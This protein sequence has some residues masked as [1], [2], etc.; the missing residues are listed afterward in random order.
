MAHTI[1]MYVE[2]VAPGISL[3][4]DVNFSCETSKL[5]I[6]FVKAA[7]VEIMRQAVASAINFK[8]VYFEMS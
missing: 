7:V 2:M 8:E 6:D 1:G 5:V 3:T 4:I